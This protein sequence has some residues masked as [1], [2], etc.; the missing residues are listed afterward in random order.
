[1]D[2]LPIIHRM[3]EEYQKRSG[4]VLLRVCEQCGR[5][6]DKKGA[7]RP[8]KI[9][10]WQKA[11]REERKPL[12]LNSLV[13]HHP[14]RPLSVFDN[15]R[16]LIEKQMGLRTG[17]EPMKKGE[18]IELMD[19]LSDAYR[20][21]SPDVYARAAVYMR[22]LELLSYRGL[23]KV[24]T[25][26]A[27]CASAWDHQGHSLCVECKENY[28]PFHYPSCSPCL[29][30]S[31]A[32]GK[33]QTQ[34]RLLPLPAANLIYTHRIDLTK[35]LG[36][37][38]WLQKIGDQDLARVFFHND[39]LRSSLND[40]HYLSK[41]GLKI[42]FLEPGKRTGERGSRLSGIWRLSGSFDGKLLQKELSE[43]YPG[44]PDAFP[45]EEALAVNPPKIKALRL[46]DIRGLG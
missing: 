16:L 40:D 19:R 5:E 27:S 15:Y 4:R 9:R 45:M 2:E 42:S 30:S 1:M 33:G 31:K 32:H 25:F 12:R 13:I 34:K 43:S 26:C 18:D 10:V 41:L 38:G 7:E 20:R 17:T 21:H 23:H 29:R 39:R 11:R 22:Y 37:E 6:D 35:E 44:G 36:E 28:H 24:Y 46:S 14:W 3:G 8:L